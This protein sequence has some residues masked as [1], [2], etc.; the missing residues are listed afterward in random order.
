MRHVRPVFCLLHRFYFQSSKARAMSLPYET[1]KQ[2]AVAAVRRACGLTSSVFNKL[3]KNETLTKN[4][5]SPVTVGDYAAQAVISTMLYHAFPADPIVGEEDAAELREESGAGLRDR[6]VALAN[7][8]LTGELGFGDNV[9]WGIGPGQE[10]TTAQLLDAIDRGNHPGGRSGRMWTIDPIDG[11][12]GFLR[13]EQYA[14]CLSLIV[15]AQVQL[16]VIGCPNLPVDPSKPDS[17]RGVIFVAVK[18]H[19]AEQMTLSG[20]NPAP[21]R[22]PIFPPAEINFL[23]SVE[24]AHS[25]HYFNARVSSILGIT[26]PPVRMDSQAKYGCLAR[27]EGAAYLRMP[28]VVGYKEK[29]WDHAPGVVL[30]EEAG[31]VVTDSRGLPLDFGLGRTLGGNFGVVAAGMDVHALVLEAVQKA[32][33]LETGAKA[34]V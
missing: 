18:G 22:I 13:G 34:K 28:T 20:A 19:G 29:I 2:L 8:A 9:E 6:I 15:D 14:V 10:K 12:K 16:G 3:V 25:S 5:K 4:D 33:A 26:H 24:A 27:G 32:Q 17:A 7:E 31:G 1:E 11:T 30:I 23:E 21:L